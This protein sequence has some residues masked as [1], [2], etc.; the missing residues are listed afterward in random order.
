MALN[1][2]TLLLRRELVNGAVDQLAAS[3]LDLSGLADHLAAE[4]AAY[5]LLITD[6]CLVSRLTVR[7][8]DKPFWL[9]EMIIDRG[10]PWIGPLRPPTLTLYTQGGNGAAAVLILNPLRL[11]VSPTVPRSCV[12]A[13]RLLARLAAAARPAAG[14]PAPPWTPGAKRALRSP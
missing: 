6:R 1:T 2:L 7:V 13:L 3:H 12:P 14:H 4:E 11:R 10:R 9:A 5:R 8:A